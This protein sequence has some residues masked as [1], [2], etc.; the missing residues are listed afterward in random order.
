MAAEMG[1]RAGRAWAHRGLK[2]RP[3]LRTHLAL[4]ILRI[5]AATTT[6]EKI[7]SAANTTYFCVR[8]SMR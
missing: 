4:G 5:C 2:G 6:D 8:F 1:V 7:V 3:P